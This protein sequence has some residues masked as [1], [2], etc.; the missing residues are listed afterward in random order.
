MLFL[1]DKRDAALRMSERIALK[2]D[3]SSSTR[4]KT[5]KSFHGYSEETPDLSIDTAMSNT[6]NTVTSDEFLFCA[7]HKS[8]KTHDTASCRGF[9]SMTRHSRIEALKKAGLCFR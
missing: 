4:P 7:V 9:K 5:S 1:E 3:A 8:N 6:A 2:S